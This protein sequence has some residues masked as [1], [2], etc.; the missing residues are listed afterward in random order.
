MPRDFKKEATKT[1]AARKAWGA[2]VRQRIE[3]IHQRV[4]AHDVLRHGGVELRSDGEEQFSCPFHG[5]DAKPSARV[6]PESVRSNSHAWCFVCQERWDAIT[7]WRKFDSAS[8][9]KTFSRTLKE[10]EQAFGLTTPE[11]PADAS[12]Y[13]EHSNPHL[14]SFDILYEAA[15]SYLIRARVAY[16]HLDDM[17]GFLSAGQVLDKVKFRVDSSKMDPQAGEKILRELL[18]R[19]KRKEKSCPVG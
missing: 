1:E 8:E 15:E 7:L 14:E 6:Y 2:W 18:N 4:T 17:K 3:A 9:G 12:E 19:I 11:M 16:R 5:V 10:M 13:Q